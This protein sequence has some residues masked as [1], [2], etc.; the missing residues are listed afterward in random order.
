MTTKY[1]ALNM[2]SAKVSEIFQATP[3]SKALLKLFKARERN[4]KNRETSVLVA[5]KQLMKM[6]L[7]SDNKQI[8]ST[9]R[10]LDQAGVCK[11]EGETAKWNIGIKEI[12]EALCGE[13]PAPYKEPVKKPTKVDPAINLVMVLR[14]GKVV[15][16]ESYS[17]AELRELAEI[18]K[19]AA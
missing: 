15:S 5:H 8:K 18:L 9:F 19:K 16:L 10:A 11:L 1:P 13:V 3:T 4:A 7:P 14:S 17:R 6:G 12:A 2:N